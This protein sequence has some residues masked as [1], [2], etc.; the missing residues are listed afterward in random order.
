MFRND[1]KVVFSLFM[2]LFKFSRFI[3]CSFDSVS[4]MLFVCALLGCV[5]FPFSK[6][7]SSFLLGYFCLSTLD[8]SGVLLVSCLFI[9]WCI[10]SISRSENQPFFIIVLTWP[11]SLWLVV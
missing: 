5:A 1:G 11:A 10:S 3:I 7:G 2:I 6:V 8:V 9:F 4:L